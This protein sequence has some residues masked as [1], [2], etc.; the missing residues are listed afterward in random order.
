MKIVESLKTQA[1]ARLVNISEETGVW[2]LLGCGGSKQPSPEKFTQEGVQPE[3]V[4][5]HPG[6]DHSAGH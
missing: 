5:L 1:D 6:V 3:H 4:S 2:R